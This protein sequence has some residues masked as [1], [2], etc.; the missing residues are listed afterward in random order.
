MA[1]F[2]K[3]IMLLLHETYTYDITIDDDTASGP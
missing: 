1:D 3:K 2:V